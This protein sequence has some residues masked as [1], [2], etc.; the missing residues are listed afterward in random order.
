MS[1]ESTVLI[2]AVR[3]VAAAKRR[4]LPAHPAADELVAYQEQQ[5][6]GA[7]AARVREHLAICP[8]CAQLVLD[9][10]TFPDVPLRDA[11]M[12]L[13]PEEDEEDFEALLGQLPE[14]RADVVP[15]PA[16]APGPRRWPVLMMAASLLLGVLGLGLWLGG[17]GSPL[18]PAPDARAAVLLDL[19]PVAPDARGAGSEEV[20]EI[21]AGDAHL[22]LVLNA[23]DLGSFPAYE[24]EVRSGGRL[25]LRGAGLKPGAKDT[26]TLIVPRAALPADRYEVLLFGS[27]E[28]AGNTRIARYLVE[29][30]YDDRP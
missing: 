13:S 19:Y 14:Q 17:V 11:A 3:E 5:L 4:Q 28:D 27:S 20:V 10:S 9:L 21:P 25:V 7:A 22:V 1:E 15:L 6:P 30:A 8:E 16:P 2:E 23:S 26:V 18:R 12:A 29:V 24:A